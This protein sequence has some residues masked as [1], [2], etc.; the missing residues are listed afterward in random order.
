MMKNYT[1]ISLTLFLFFVMNAEAQDIILDQL[2]GS[3]FSYVSGGKYGYIDENKEIVISYKYDYAEPFGFKG[4]AKVKHNL[5]DKFYYYIDVQG[6]VSNLSHL[7]D[8][9]HKLQRQ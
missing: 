1:T 2:K 7:D 9:K 5:T 6:N 3:E 8:T 4:Y